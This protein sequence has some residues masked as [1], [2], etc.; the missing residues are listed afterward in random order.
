MRCAS[1][2]QWNTETFESAASATHS[3]TLLCLCCVIRVVLCDPVCGLRFP[4]SCSFPP[5][6]WT[7]HH[8]QCARRDAFRSLKTQLGEVRRLYGAWRRQP[9][10]HRRILCD[11]SPAAAARAGPHSTDTG[12]ET[13]KHGPESHQL[14]GP[15]S[16]KCGPHLCA[17]AERASSSSNVDSN[18]T[19]CV[20]VEWCTVSLSAAR[21]RGSSWRPQP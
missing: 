18:K 15:S 6:F 12:P 17:H 11:T 9:R 19:K 8:G 4:L 10:R 2:Y 1:G 16:A 13:T 14:S 7:R 5:Y 20:V 21:L 3:N